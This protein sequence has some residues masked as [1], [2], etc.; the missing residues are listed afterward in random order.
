MGWVCILV[1]Y[2]RA[3]YV[4]SDWR[5]M[6]VRCGRFPLLRRLRR[7]AVGGGQACDAGVFF[8]A[9]FVFGGGRAG[10]AGGFDLFAAFLRFLRFATGG[11]FFICF[12]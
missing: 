4:F 7:F 2:G 5:R 11:R 6:G 1:G 8:A 9:V 10:D 12:N 3:S